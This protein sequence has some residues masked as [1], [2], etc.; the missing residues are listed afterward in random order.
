MTAPAALLSSGRRL[1]L[2]TAAAV[3]LAV[4]VFTV[5]IEELVAVPG[6]G[7]VARLA[8]LVALAFGALGMF[9]RG[10]VRFH[11]PLLIVLVAVAYVG[12]SALGIYW[13]AQPAATIRRVVTLAQLLVF[14]WL[15]TEYCRDRSKL[16]LLLQ[17][18]V[19]G[20]CVAF[21]VTLANALGSDFTGFRDVGRFDAN[22]FAAVLA[23]GI[24][25]AALIAA[26]RR[27]G[28]LHVVN[29]AY[30][31]IAVFGVVLAASRGGLVTCLVALLVVPFSMTQL[32]A[33][34]RVALL[35]GVVA[36]LGLSF[37]FAPRVFPELYRN[38]DRLAGTADELAG[39]TLTGRTTIWAE[40]LQVF[41]E[42]P[43]VGV[44]AGAAR[45]ALASGE[46]GRNVVAHNVFLAVAADTGAVGL[47][48]FLALIGVA[49]A[50]AF[51]A[52]SRQRPFLIVLALALVVAM[53]PISIEARKATWFTLVALALHQP[54]VVS[55]WWS[56]A[57][58]AKRH[59]TAVSATT[60]RGP[61]RITRR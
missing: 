26:E 57:D 39:G 17:A 25:M 27:M 48:L 61:A 11:A 6:V 56:R 35:L 33:P 24:P 37:A 4:F 44:G 29:L 7:S 18:F 5:P 12:W 51:L 32:P 13:S 41:W 15:M 21:G 50:A 9:G 22:E 34:R 19:L 20:N 31:V 23:L 45:H 28:F 30:P 40:T 36:A 60:D 59:A 55:G 38:L 46:F 14:A 54:V 1:D 47:L 16:L 2:R 53:M 52:P 58:P 8:G 43:L 42:S 3:A 49:V 10:R